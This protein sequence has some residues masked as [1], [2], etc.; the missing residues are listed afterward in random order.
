MS[1]R[2]Y[3]SHDIEVIGY[4]IKGDG[5][6]M[7]PITPVKLKAYN[8]SADSKVVRFPVK[9]RRIHYRASNCGEEVFKCNPEEW[10][11]AEPRYTKGRHEVAV[12]LDAN[13]TYT[14]KGKVV[15]NRGLYIP[16]CKQVVIEPGTEIVL[17]PNAYLVSYAPIEANGTKDRPIYIK[18][19]SETTQGF[20]CLS[21]ESSM[22]SHTTF[23]GLGTMNEGNWRLTGAVTFYNA[24][25]SLEHC[26]FKNNH[27]EDALNTISCD[28]D[29]S[30]CVV[31]NTYSDG[32][33]ADFCDGIVTNSEFRNTGN[34]CIDFSGSEFIIDHCTITNSGDKGVSGGEGSTLEVTNCTIKGAQI[35][36]ASKDRSKVTVDHIN[37][38]QSDVAYSAYRKKAEYGP[39][40][41]I[42]KSED[43]NKATSL[44]LLE[45]DSKLVHKGKEYVGT[46]RFNIDEMYAQF[47]KK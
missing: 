14:L 15:I 24:R 22:L 46:E 8:T 27:C 29:M 32:Y 21:R 36:V 28:V 6:G 26:S 37:I 19:T 18:G 1:L 35:A 20:V 7:V 11:E 34:D 3:H 33:D 31:D 9:P 42:V 43:S 38:V 2:N 17:G 25:V 40:V 41:L 5:I 30:H 4:T 23:D 47:E 12:V 39:A 45:L 44:K 10:P 13:D 16:K